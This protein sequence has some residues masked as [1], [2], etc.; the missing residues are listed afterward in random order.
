LNSSSKKNLEF[1]FSS[2]SCS[3]KNY[4]SQDDPQYY[5]FYDVAV[6]CW[7]PEH[8]LWG[9]CIG[10]PTLIFGLLAPFATLAYWTR[11]KDLRNTAKIQRQYT[12]IFKSYQR[13][14]LFWFDFF[15]EG[16]IY[17]IGKLLFL[18]EKSS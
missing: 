7:K 15:I 9:L 18:A 10:I 6:Q 8:L 13:N 11:E 2:H 4:G 17:L 3:C 14:A 16:V 5:L 1:I 12:F